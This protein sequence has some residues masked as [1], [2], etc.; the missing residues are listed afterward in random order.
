MAAA[1]GWRASPETAAGFSSRYR[2]RI[3]PSESDATPK[4]HLLLIEDSADVTDALRILFEHNG[5]RVSTAANVAEAVQIGVHDTPEVV[6]LDISLADGEDGLEVLR[7]W[8]EC[9]VIAPRVLALTGHT[10]DATRERCKAAGCQEVLLK[11][12]PSAQLL[13]YVGALR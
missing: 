11:P 1:S 5:Y 9:G 3:S 13:A 2:A 6:L 10:D 4:S 12:V 7:R 8:H